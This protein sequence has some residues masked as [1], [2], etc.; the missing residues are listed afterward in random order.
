MAEQTTATPLTA[1]EGAALLGKPEQLGGAPS[2]PVAEDEALTDAARAAAHFASDAK[3]HKLT[4][5]REDGVFRHVE[6]TGLAGLSR[7]A[8]ITWPFNLLVAGSHGSYHFERYGA[9]TEDMFNWLRGSRVNADSWASKLINGRDSVTEYSREKLVAEVGE[10]VQE[11]LVDGWAPE[12][13]AAA[14]AEE[15]LGSHLLDNEGTALQLV[16]EFEHGE[17]HRAECSCGAASEAFDNYSAAVCWNAATHKGRGKAHQVR[18]RQ[19]G[20]FDFTDVG[21][22][23][24][25]KLNYHYLWT[26]HAMVWA[27][28]Q[29]DAAKQAELPF[30]QPG[31]TY[32]REHHGDTIH[33]AVDHLSTSPDGAQRVACGWRQ[34]SYSDAWEPSDADDMDGWT[35]VTAEE[36]VT[37]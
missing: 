34:R 15:I 3:A 13:L 33:F 35:E 14:V 6:F 22:W 24:I 20:G 37:A 12:G 4:V 19:V 11:A 5:H 25:R 8:L 36:A 28:G 1:E 17:Q 31:R 16:D 32:V 26:C 29:Y 2:V 23:N 9:D 30:F 7:I 21:D 10:R 18:V 27:I